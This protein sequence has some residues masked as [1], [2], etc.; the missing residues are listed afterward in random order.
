M[1]KSND[2]LKNQTWKNSCQAQLL[3]KEVDEHMDLKPCIS[4]TA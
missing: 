1:G 4:L 2:L 3:L